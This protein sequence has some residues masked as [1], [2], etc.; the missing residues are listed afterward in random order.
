MLKLRNWQ[1]EAF[2]KAVHWFDQG[3]DKRFLINAAPGAGKTICASIIAKDLIEKKKI[4]TVI[5]V[6]PRTE[7][8][9]QWQEAFK[10][11]TGRKMIKITGGYEDISDFDGSDLC[12]T[13]NAIQNAKD[14]FEQISRKKKVLV[15]CDEHHHA[16]I[17]AAWGDSAFDAFE[18]SKYVIVL[19]GTPVRTDGNKP[20]W[21]SYA[22]DGKSQLTHP[23]EGT[24]TLTYG[25][26]VRLKYCRPAFFHRHRGKFS[27]LLKNEGEKITSVSSEGISIDTEGLGDDLRKSI[28]KSL[29]FYTL[30]RMPLYEKDNK[31]PRLDTYQKSMLEWGIEKLKDT[32]ERMEKAGGLV[33]APNIKVAEFMAVLLERLTKEKPSIVHSNTKGDPN[34]IIDAFR[35]NK[36]DWIVSVG[37]ISEGVDI[38]RL[39]ILVYLPNSQTEL[40]FRQALGRVV[41]SYDDEDDTSAYVIIPEFNIFEEYARRVEDEMIQSNFKKDDHEINKKKCQKCKE[42]ND[43]ENEFCIFCN[44]EFPK[45]KQEFKKC[46][47]CDYSNP[48]YLD[49]CQN[50]GENF[51]LEYEVTLSEALRQGGIA[52]GVDIEEEDVTTHLEYTAIKKLLLESGDTRF[53]EIFKVIPEEALKSLS[54]TLNKVFK[55]DDFEI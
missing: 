42:E 46:E 27:V 22:T 52:R 29:D 25:E 51:S 28:K 15:I 3:K 11:V 34:N 47:K 7:V 12:S 54:K 8:V 43:K 21:F 40:S 23:Q 44:F 38:K 5:V 13:W 45:R 4:D 35:N 18:N 10:A 50:C 24:Y 53:L 49:S 9:S 6:A 32:Q 31:T 17:N 26:C 41:R 1:E 48:V 2:K 55:K 36:K 30:A 14:L 19:T 16:A 20:V 39:R 37:M 33:I